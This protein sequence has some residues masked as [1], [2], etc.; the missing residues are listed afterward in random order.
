LVEIIKKN[1]KMLID[2][3]EDDLKVKAA[4]VAAVV[5]V[6]EILANLS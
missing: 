4:H 1:T 6:L 5:W 3:Y 2:C